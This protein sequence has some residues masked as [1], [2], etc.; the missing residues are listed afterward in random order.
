MDLI[1]NTISKQ[2]VLIDTTVSTAQR[3][4]YFDATIK[5]VACFASGHRKTYKQDLC[6]LDIKFRK[7]VRAI[8]GRPG[9]LVFF[10]CPHA[11]LPR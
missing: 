1:W 4:A 10:F 6:K 9:G 11:F 2:S 7:L 3:L 8:V 5:P